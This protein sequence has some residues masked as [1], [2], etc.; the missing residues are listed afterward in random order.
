MFDTQQPKTQYHYQEKI[1]Q[2]P[3]TIAQ[4]KQLVLLLHSCSFWF[5]D[6]F[7]KSINN[8]GTNK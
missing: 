6:C 4:L 2:Q 7:G 3:V 8:D 5:F 1:K